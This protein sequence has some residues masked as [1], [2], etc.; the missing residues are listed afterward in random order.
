MILSMLLVFCLFYKIIIPCI[1]KY[2]IEPQVKLMIR[3]PDMIGQIY[4]SIRSRTGLPWGFSGKESAYQC[5]R[6]RFDPWSVKIPHAIEQL[7]PWAT[8][9]ELVLE[10]RIHHQSPSGAAAKACTPWSLSTA[11]EATSVRSSCTATG[12]AAAHHGW[13]RAPHSNKTPAQP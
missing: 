11:R 1:I 7:R 8:T 3:W 13:R 6:H 4:S 12:V 2:V 9:A 5:R 10:P